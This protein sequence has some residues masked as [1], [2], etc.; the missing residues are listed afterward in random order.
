MVGFWNWNLDSL[1]LVVAETGAG[2]R[3]GGFEGMVPE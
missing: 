1:F 2:G 3:V